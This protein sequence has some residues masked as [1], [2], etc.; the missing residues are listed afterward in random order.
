MVTS[1]GLKPCAAPQSP[2]VPPTSICPLLRG[3]LRGPR[4]LCDRL[5]RGDEF[6]G[7]YVAEGSTAA[8]R[9]ADLDA[10]LRSFELNCQ[11]ADI[12]EN[13]G[14]AISRHC[15]R[16]AFWC[17]VHQIR[18]GSSSVTPDDSS[19]GNRALYP[20]LARSAGEF[21]FRFFGVS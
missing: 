12:R 21:H 20:Y 5:L 18:G 16:A 8:G 9:L 19:V 11:A 6:T 7:S 14:S 2:C 1:D 3:H 15:R 4:G 17:L 13:P 10:R